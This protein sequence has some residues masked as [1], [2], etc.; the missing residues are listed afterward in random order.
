M[1]L[2]DKGKLT[3]LTNIMIMLTNPYNQLKTLII[4][5]NELVNKT[6]IHQ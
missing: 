2:L 3:L 5:F 4:N 1:Q 6:H